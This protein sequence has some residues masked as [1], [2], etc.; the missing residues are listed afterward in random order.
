MVGLHIGLYLTISVPNLDN[1]NALYCAVIYGYYDL[2]HTC[3]DQ[4]S[5]P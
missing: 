3:S 1:Y 4:Y 2:L 5:N